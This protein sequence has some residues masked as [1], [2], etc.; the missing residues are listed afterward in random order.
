[1]RPDDPHDPFCPTVLALKLARRSNGVSALH[2]RVAR[3]MWRSLFPGRVE[4][5][6]PIGHIT[7]GIHVP[8]CLA[9]EMQD[10]FAHELGPDWLQGICHP[11]L[12][13]RA[14]GI[15]DAEL[16]EVHQVLKARLLAFVRRHITEARERVGL[17]APDAGALDPEVLTIGFARRFAT[18]KR[19]DLLLSDLDRLH[20]LVTH[21][22]RPVQII[23]AGRSHPHDWG[24][25]A[26]IQKIARASLDPRF[27]GRIAFLENYNIHVGRQLVHGVDAWLNNPRRPLEA[28]G[29]SGE[30][31]ILNGGLHISILDGWWAEAYDGANGF[32]IGAGESHVDPAVQD[33]RDAATLFAT[34]ENE[35]IPLYYD[36]EPASGL[37]H[38][39]I[40]R[41]KRAMRTLAWR[42]NADRMVMD[43]V[44]ECYLPAALAVSSRMPPA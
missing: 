22:T 25:K 12:W 38:R 18:Y 19:A 14:E 32:A 33:R 17:P 11:D 44:R 31:V 3:R 15:D 43:Y 37:P 8:T 5:E 27:Q 2:G 10:L 9:P 23:F 30:K 39:W 13:V 24:G 29:T 34:L 40:H 36:R 42:F 21:K 26:L 16:W 28:C 41:V 6:I 35:V 4:E 1:V 20:A 7:N